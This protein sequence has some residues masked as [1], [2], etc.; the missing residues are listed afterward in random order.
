MSAYVVDKTHIDAMLTAGLDP[1]W[2]RGNPLR[3]LD[4]PEPVTN[5]EQGEAWGP[6]WIAWTNQHLQRLTDETAGRVGAMLWAENRR[7]VNH[8]YVEDEWEEPYEFG[9]LRGNPEP[10]IVLMAIDC[11]E[12]Q[13]RHEAPYDLAEMKGLRLHAVAAA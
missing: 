3:W 1:A 2:H 5:Y 13:V 7:S 8:R 10:T 12:Y 11:Y 6:G 4:E 9:R